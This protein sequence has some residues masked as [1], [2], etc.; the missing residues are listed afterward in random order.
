[1]KDYGMSK[2]PP[3]PGESDGNMPKLPP[4][5]GETSLQG[6]GSQSLGNY[7]LVKPPVGLFLVS[8]FILLFTACIFIAPGID[9]SL[10]VTDRWSGDRNF[11][12]FLVGSFLNT[13]ILGFF[14]KED[15]ERRSTLRYVESRIS[16][17][18]LVPW[19]TF[20]SWFLG[21]VHM[22]FFAKE[23]TRA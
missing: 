13:A 17:R 10:L 7:E 1:V 6:G 21:L 19:F 12:G 18:F 23:L 9:F 11:L 15:N 14:L 20:I 2:L 5:P 22:F 16:P 3:L 4:L 8:F